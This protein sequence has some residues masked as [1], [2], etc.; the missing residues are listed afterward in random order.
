LGVVGS[1]V[2]VVVGLGVV[3][4]SGV[5]VAKHLGSVDPTLHLNIVWQ[6]G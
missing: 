5:L 6:L 3:V 4:G 2:V 1:G